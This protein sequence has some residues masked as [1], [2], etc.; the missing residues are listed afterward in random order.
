MNNPY[1]LHDPFIRD[2]DDWRLRAA[3]RGTTTPDD[4]F[5][6]QSSG[7]HTNAVKSALETC[8]T[9]PVRWDCLRTATIRDRGIWGGFTEAERRAYERESA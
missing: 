7:L 3:C 8:H 5:P 1:Q 6:I 2:T 4:W 9:C